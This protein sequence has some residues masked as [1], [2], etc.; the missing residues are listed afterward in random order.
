M[1]KVGSTKARG[2]SGRHQALRKQY[3]RRMARGERFDCWRCGQPIEPG[4]PFDLGHDD[5]DRN[6]Y[7]GPEH[8][9][10]ECPKGG[11]RATS[12]RRKTN[13]PTRWEL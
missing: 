12:G 9:G 7:R 3:K 6:I 2:Y 5:H 10:R 4:A 11:N 8:V 13:A 1:P